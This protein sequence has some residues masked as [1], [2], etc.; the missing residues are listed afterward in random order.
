MKM[1]LWFISQRCLEF[2]CRTSKKKGNGAVWHGCW[3][4]SW[5][6]LNLFYNF[7][8]TTERTCLFLHSFMD[9][10]SDMPPCALR[11]GIVNHVFVY[12]D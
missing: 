11:V 12:P 5:T 2:G 1:C 7:A 4:V 10:V 6:I 9:I 8:L 3:S